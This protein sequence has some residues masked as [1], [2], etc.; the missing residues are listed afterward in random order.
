VPITLRGQT[1]GVLGLEDPEGTYQWSEEDQALVEAVSQQLA[2]ALENARLLDVTQRRAARERLSR[3]ITDTIRS[4]ASVEDAIQRAVNEIGRV[5]GVSEMVAR[6]GTEQDLL[7][8][9]GG[10]GHE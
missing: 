9:Q 5:L 1:I 4:A 2:L 8:G 7:A 6:L 3:E 10:N